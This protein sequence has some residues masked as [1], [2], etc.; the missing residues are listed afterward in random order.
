MRAVLEI[1]HELRHRDDIF[2]LWKRRLKNTTPSSHRAV[3]SDRADQPR[4]SL[5]HLLASSATNPLGKSEAK[6]IVKE[7]IPPTPGK[8]GTVFQPSKAKQ[9]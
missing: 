3:E 8:S 1:P 9:G 2:S 5:N 6:K 7:Q 4:I